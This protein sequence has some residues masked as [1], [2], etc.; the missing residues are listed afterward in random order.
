MAVLGRLLFGSSGRLDLPDLLSIESYVSADFKYLI[1]S[2][3]GG[4]Q[5]YILKG[6]DVI[7]PQD[8]IG[9][10]NISIRIADSVVYYPG[11]GAG[12][13]YYGLPEGNVN[14]EPL[15]PELRKN[16]TNFI[17]LTF[18]TF[19]TAKDSRAFWDTDQNGGEGGEFSQDVNTQS[20]LTVDVNTSVS[21]FPDN[22]IPICK[23]KVGPSV[24]ETIQD[25]RDMMFRLGKGGVSPNPF[26]SYSFREDP[27]APYSR[28]EPSTT[29][30]SALDPNPFQGGD[31][32]IL[33]L[34][35]WM[36]VVMTRLKEISGTT[37][38]Y[39]NSVSGSSPI[40]LGNIFLD[41]LGSTLKSKGQWQH[42]DSIAG[43]ATWTEDIHYLSLKD[44]R[45]VIL[46]AGTIALA[47]DQV[48]WIDIDRDQEINGSSQ[49]VNWL[50]GSSEITGVTG[51]F[52]NLSK[53]DW[54]KKKTDSSDKYLRVEEFYATSGFGGGTTTPAL[55]QSVRLSAN[56]AGTSGSEIGE[57]TRGEYLV[58]DVQIT[59][60]NSSS[61]QSAGG[62]FFWLAYRSDTS[63]GLSGISPTQLTIDI[64]EADGQRARVTSTV[65]HGLVDGDRVTITTGP[66]AGTYQVEV[67]D[68]D[69]FF[70]DTTVT[71][72][73]LAQSAFY[74]IV[75]TA[76]RNN[77]YSY[78][79]ETANHGFASN[80]RV[81]V[82][83]TSTLYDSSYLINVRSATTFQ[84]PI[85]SLI[86]NPG[87][88]AG[89]IIVLPRMNVRTEFG[90]VKIVQGEE[91]NIGEMDSKNILSF[92][93]MDSLAQLKPVYSLPSSANMLRGHENYNS[94]ADD[95]LTVRAARLTAMM[96]DRI[97]DRGL[98]IVGR[99]NISNITNGANQDIS[100]LSNLTLVKPSSP[101]QTIT[102][103]SPISLPT[104]S[105]IVI[106]IDRDGNTAIIPSVISLGNN[107]LLQENRI[108]LF[109]RF[110]ATK[111]YDWN[112]N[113]ISAYGHINTEN[114]EDA[115]NK[116]VFVLNP[117]TVSL[118]INTDLLTLD[119]KRF[120]EI[121][122]ITVVDALYIAQSSYFTFAAAN[123]STLYYVWYNKDGLGID[124][125]LIGYTGIQINISTGDLATVIAV[126]TRNAIN[127]F[128]GVD[129]TCPM[130]IT[131]TI[132]ITNNI[133]GPAT[134]AADG[135]PSTG[136]NIEVIQRGSAENISIVI[137][138]SSD[139]IIDVD[140]VNGLGSLFIA[141]GSSI[142][143]RINRFASKTFNTIAFVDGSDTDVAG[144]LYSTA[145]S[146]VPTD[147][148]VFILWTRVG[149]NIL[150]ANAISTPD[151][152]VYDEWFDVVSGVPAN[153]YEI[154]GPISINTVIN[155][156]PD[157]RDSGNAQ[158]YV[159]GSGQL[160]VFLNGQYLRHGVDWQEV[161][162]QF[163]LSKQIKLLQNIVV[164]DSI[165]FRIDAD[166][167][168]YTST[169]GGGGGGGGSLQD[170][171]DIGRFI[172][173]NTGQPIVIT[174]PAGKLLSIQGDLEVTGVIDPTALQLTPQATSPLAG[175][176][177]GIWVSTTGELI[178]QKGDESAPVN[179]ST[180]VESVLAGDNIARSIKVELI[181]NTGNPLTSLTPVV[182]DTSGEAGTIDVSSENLST[183]IIG[184]VENTITNGNYGNVITNGCIKN[185]STT[186]T[187]GVVYISKTGTL[188]NTKPSIGVEGFV[189]G[190]FVIGIGVISK[191]V[192]NPLQKDIIIN[193]Q[194]VGQL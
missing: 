3:I 47:D 168:V 71:G 176:Q 147:Q 149:D 164:G 178:H 97:Q 23:V 66:Y 36:D 67:V 77:G 188:T 81:T 33:T 171:Y 58:G 187:F 189:A 62:N 1:Q 70:I 108:V 44:N 16:A 180:A 57:Y 132:T 78:S 167:G 87:A 96:A 141:D 142:W 35:E 156:P 191:N 157:S 109:Y 112:G 136:F 140:V 103:T 10:E 42:S 40:S 160:E 102:L 139:N 110:G 54:V 86:P 185:I 174:G 183:S 194:V 113:A 106:D 144:K 114:P 39:E 137:P 165:G 38:W 6:L 123:N 49:T 92:I 14:A 177:A 184:L 133:D 95:N 179:V 152:N 134:D 26:N 19:D 83:G 22:T 166:G 59:S 126:A 135:T 175:N 45:D 128:A 192:T 63:L 190:D 161:G 8:S 29:M 56:Y 84:I 34:K 111:V 169:S 146:S 101:D 121:T 130:P 28:L 163:A 148:D 138:G 186:A 32:N 155:I 37:Y 51:S 48:A 100:A 119:V 193:V 93:G 65:A 82:Q 90:T 99:T 117:G 124:P 52:A 80:E 120:E 159:V 50:N 145:T 73:S 181:N 5:P 98:M 91:V 76:A 153:P 18:N 129:V 122:N 13:F 53:G 170:A 27:S 17:Y 116:N 85:G 72:D 9:T 151:G 74:A 158:Y 2:L 182:V 115:Q 11:S 61:I 150:I 118:D 15:V 79:L 12:S 20:V 154:Q 89:E 31:K 41:A 30:T 127:A 24:V 172:A 104:N 162:N 64:T 7:S 125:A 107:L 55:A 88:I 105:A 173:V 46:R 68:T 131:P 4:D 25:C 21:G 60:R 94:D 143:V 69:D 43:Q 75:T